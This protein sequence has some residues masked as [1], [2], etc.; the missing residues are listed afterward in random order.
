MSIRTKLVSVLAALPVVATAVFAV[1]PPAQAVDASQVL[2]AAKTAYDVYQKLTKTH[3]LT[4]D[5]ATTRIIDAVNTA[6][7]DIVF[8]IDE[9]AAIPA[10][11]CARSTIID[12]EDFERLN[13][14][15]RQLFARDATYCAAEVT[16]T[17]AAIDPTEDSRPLIDNLGFAVNV[18]GAIALVARSNAGLTTGGLEDTLITANQSILSKLAPNCSTRT[19]AYLDARGKPV[20]SMADNYHTCTA[21]NNEQGYDYTR[22]RMPRTGWNYSAARAEA[23]RNTSYA[24]ALEA[25]AVLNS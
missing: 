6:R 11:A 1:A 18:V 9:M 3:E 17:L 2:Q 19:V 22:G 14:T 24:V 7:D 16:A 5:E 8:H 13:R 25:L 20:P 10:R 12:F 15:N 23:G 21:Y 4:L